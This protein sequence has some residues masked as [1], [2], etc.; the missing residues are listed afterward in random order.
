MWYLIMLIPD[1]C[2]LTYL[3]ENKMS[4]VPVCYYVKNDIFMRNWRP[5]DV[6]ADD[7]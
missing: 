2:T 6:S 5:P 7:E 3:D 1:L 4:Q